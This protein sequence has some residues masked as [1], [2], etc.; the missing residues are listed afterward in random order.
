M[1]EELKNQAKENLSKVGEVQ[2]GPRLLG[3]HKCLRYWREREILSRSVSSPHPKDCVSVLC[4]G[5]RT[6]YQKKELFSSLP[7]KSQE[8]KA[9]LF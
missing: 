4:G 3:R 5:G 8:Y 6:V 2:A 1:F 7:L 9:A